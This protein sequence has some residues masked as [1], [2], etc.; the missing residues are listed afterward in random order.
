[1]LERTTVWVTF[2]FAFVKVY[3]VRVEETSPAS[4]EDKDIITSVRGCFSKT[5]EKVAVCESPSVKRP[6]ST[7]R[8]KE[9]KS[10]S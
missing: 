10:L 7:P 8:A 5:K 9:G 3:E 2:Q 4:A 6:L 1:M